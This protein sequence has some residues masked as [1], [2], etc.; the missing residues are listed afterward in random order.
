MDTSLNRQAEIAFT[1]INASATAKALALQAVDLAR[2]KK[3][4]EA[5]KL[6]VEAR[7]SI[8]PGASA[9]GKLV[10]YEAG[11]NQ[12]T[13]SLLLMHAEDQMLTTETIIIMAEQLID[14]YKKL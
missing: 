9:H 12:F 13:V 1:I 10:Q 3:F 4:D 11:G 5:K 2:E 14:V 7:E 6:I 8:G